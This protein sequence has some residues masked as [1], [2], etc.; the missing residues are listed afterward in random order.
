[1]VSLVLVGLVRVWCWFWSVRGCG[2]PI[3]LCLFGS[4]SASVLAVAVVSLTLVFGLRSVFVLGISCK[5]GEES[6]IVITEKNPIG[7]KNPIRGRKKKNPIRNCV[8]T[9]KN[10]KNSVIN[11]I[12][13]GPKRIQLG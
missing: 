8:K 13:L 6:G 11:R 12:R 5:R 9:T 1:M 3:G 7:E 10:A 4:L 2:G